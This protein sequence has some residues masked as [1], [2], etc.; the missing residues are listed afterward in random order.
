MYF[1]HSVLEFTQMLEKDGSICSVLE[2]SI[3]QWCA[4]VG[5]G[6]LSTWGH[7]V[8]LRMCR[9][10][11]TAVQNS[12]VQANILGQSWQHTLRQISAAINVTSQPVTISIYI[13]LAVPMCQ[14]LQK[15]KPKFAFCT[16]LSSTDSMALPHS[17]DNADSVYE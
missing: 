4:A 3:S 2:A 15:P 6:V 9:S 1:P 5:K 17:Q 16:G 8:E 10:N 13:C 7:V 11:S 14:V 12:Y